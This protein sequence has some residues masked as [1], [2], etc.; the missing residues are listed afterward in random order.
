MTAVFVLLWLISSSAWG[1]AVS[2]I[3]MYTDPREYFDDDYACEC[4]PKE[5]CT[6]AS[7]CDVTNGGNYATINVSV[8]SKVNWILLMAAQ[9]CDSVINRKM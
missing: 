5:K 8:V 3:K 2:K 4:S 7:V 6:P 1:D 9:S